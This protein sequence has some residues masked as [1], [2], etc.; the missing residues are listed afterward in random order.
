MCGFYGHT[1]QFCPVW[2][3]RVERMT[4]RE[5]ELDKAH[6]YEPPRSEEECPGG[7]TQWR[8]VIASMNS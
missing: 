5:L 7:P 6:G 1:K 4:A 8:W 2:K 3:E